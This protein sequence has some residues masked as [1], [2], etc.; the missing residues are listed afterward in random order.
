M[1]QI[2][3]LTLIAIITLPI[4]AQ[5]QFNKYP[6]PYRKGDKWGYC[7]ED[8]NMII[9]PI[10][11]KAS[12]FWH[13][14]V[15]IKGLTPNT[16]YI[17]AVEKDGKKGYI[18]HNGKV[19][20]SPTYPVAY[21]K[22]FYEKDKSISTKYVFVQ[23][24]EDKVGLISFDGKN[25][26]I[27]PVEYD[28]IDLSITTL[29]FAKKGDN[30]YKIH[31]LTGE[32]ESISYDI[33]RDETAYFTW[34]DR[35]YA[36]D[37]PKKYYKTLSTKEIVAFKEQHQATFDELESQPILQVNEASSGY[38][39][40]SKNGKYGVIRLSQLKREQLTIY[41]APIYDEI[42]AIYQNDKNQYSEV[43]Y[44][45]VKKDGKV[46]IVN[47]FQQTVVP[48]EYENIFTNQYMRKDYWI[49][50]KNNQAGVIS[51]KNE[52]IVPMEYDKLKWYNYYT[53]IT[54]KND[55]KGWI[56]FQ[57]K[58]TISPKYDAISKVVDFKNDRSNFYELF[59]VTIN[60][61]KGYINRFGVEYFED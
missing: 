46:G 12:L 40:I 42:L 41:I 39:K 13:E 57:D 60:G 47:E 35:D 29:A 4:F 45:V 27:L 6:I 58:Y 38:Y 54:K 21:L 51:N 34:D 61:K 59:E 37:G 15:P 19:L 25:R 5:A 50:E 18:D 30:Y 3:F 22:S 52:V 23:N 43:D 32:K 7:D 33:Y 44:I 55:K 1:K 24:D 8:K 48:F 11:D 10:Y 28:K 20:L 9:E 2:T 49:V 31:P 14:E 26:V 56:D 53:V 36:I 17:S 16:M